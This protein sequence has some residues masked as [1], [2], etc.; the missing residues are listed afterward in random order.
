MAVV[1][2]KLDGEN[3]PAHMRGEHVNKIF[4]V[5]D[6][7]GESHYLTD[8]EEA[9]RLAVELSRPTSETGDKTD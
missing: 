7:K 6:A 9:A 8:D 3:I 4:K 1:V 5:T 2:T